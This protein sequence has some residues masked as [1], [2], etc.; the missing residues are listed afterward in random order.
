MARY[1]L[2]R[3]ASEDI[4]D[5]LVY[6]EEQFGLLTAQRYGALLVTALGDIALDPALFGSVSRKDIGAD[7]R[8]YHLRYSRIRARGTSG[9][10]G[11]PRHFL[12]YRSLDPVTVGIGRVLHDAMDIS[13]HLPPGFGEL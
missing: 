11:A 6:T 1:R 2:S 8:S 12:F 5:I 3:A 4:E 9:A 13:R 10:A 7:V